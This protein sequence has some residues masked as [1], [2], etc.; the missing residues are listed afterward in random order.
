M[1]VQ[2]LP[3]PLRKGLFRTFLLLTFFAATKPLHAQNHDAPK[4]TSG[5]TAKL[6]NIESAVN[7]P[8]RFSAS[9]HNGTATQQVYE[10]KS[11]LPIGWQ[12]SYR[13]DGSQVTSVNLASGQTREIAIEIT[14]SGNAAVRKYIIPIKAVSSSLTLPLQLEAVVKGSYGAS[15]STPSGRLSEELTAGS[16]KDIELE[17]HNTGTLPLSSLS[18]SSQ[19]PTGWEAT[20]SPSQIER[21]DGGKKVTIKATLKV[22]DKT[23]AG[24]Y[25]A[26]FTLGGNNTNAQAAFRIFV[27]TSVLSGWIGILIIALAISV[28]YVLIRK[29]GRR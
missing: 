4:E 16:H 2:L 13:V 23:I 28:V 11:E 21:L 20:F 24:D 14:A 19:L 22:P 10:L 1:S 12:I 26:T 9:L 7:E 5:F 8:F 25:S 3:K 18:I 27:K 6:V 29:Y 15:L 17:L